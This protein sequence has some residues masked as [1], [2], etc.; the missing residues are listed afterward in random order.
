MPQTNLEE[1]LEVTTHLQMISKYG[2]TG[3]LKK[4]KRKTDKSLLHTPSGPYFHLINLPLRFVLNLLHGH[5][6]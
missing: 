2:L 5:R 6:K 3:S 4:T 1:K